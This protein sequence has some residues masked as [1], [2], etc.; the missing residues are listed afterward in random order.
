MSYIV[1]QWVI[2]QSDGVFLLEP[3]GS[4]MLAQGVVNAS[5]QYHLHHGNSTEL[6]KEGGDGVL[7]TEHEAR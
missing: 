4:L 6:D 5:F 1:W 2:S 7:D 3:G